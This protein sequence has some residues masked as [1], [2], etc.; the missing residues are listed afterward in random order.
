MRCVE[1]SGGSLFTSLDHLK[2]K[3][4]P[5]DI[6][7]EFS[8][9]V[10]SLVDLDAAILVRDLPVADNVTVL[11]D[12]E[13]LVAKVMLPRVEV[14]PEPEVSEELEGEAAEGAEGEAA[15]G[16]GEEG[17]ADGEAAPPE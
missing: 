1:A 17:S 7:H 3:A 2:V 16:A 9:D 6:P 8:V 13:E 15:E 10:T 12:P 11:N 14:E 5:S 4:L